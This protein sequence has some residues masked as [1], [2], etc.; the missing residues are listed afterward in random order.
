MPQIKNFGK[1]ILIKNFSTAPNVNKFQGE[2]EL[3]GHKYNSDEWTNISP[4]II[5]KLG[6]NLHIKQNHPLSIVRQRIVNHFYRTYS[7]RIGN[8]IFSVFDNLSPV[9]TTLQNFDSLLV[10]SDHPSRKKSDCYYVNQDLMLRAHT[11]CHQSE[12]ISMGLDNFL[13]VGDVYRRDEIDATHYPVFHQV[14]GVRLCTT[15]EVFQN[16]KNPQGLSIF[17]HRGIETEYKQGCHSLESVK[18]M[19]HDLKNALVG[20]AE[21]LFGTGKICL[22]INKTTYLKTIV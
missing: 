4:K 9:V 11:T 19:E 16:V 22:V 8:P 3:L 1:N 18:I 10:P 7:N 12:L 6:S 21:S 13:V 5:T 2:I 17:E 20:L 15:T 14:D